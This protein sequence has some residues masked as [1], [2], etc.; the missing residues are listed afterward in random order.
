MSWWVIVNP[1]AGRGH[2]LARRADAA[3]AARGLAFRLAE[4]ESGPDVARLVADGV[5]AG[6]RDFVSVGGDGT[7]HLVLNALMA[8]SWE[9]PPTLAILPAGSGSDFIRTFALP[10]RLED[11]A[12]HLTTADRYPTDIGVIEGGFG[13]RFFLNAVNIGVAAASA[14]RAGRLP[15]RLGP[16]RYSAAFWLTLAG[17]PPGRATVRAGRGEFTGDVVNVTVAN[18]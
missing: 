10:K 16:I 7:A 17:F 15:R 2:E 11:A 9:R 3:L 18:G 6:Y 14:T 13:R 5:D 1:S 12:D 8:H 4:S